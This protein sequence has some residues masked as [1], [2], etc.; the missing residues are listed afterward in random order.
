MK[1][2]IA[3]KQYPYYGGSAT[4]AYKLIKFLRTKH[5]VIGL[6]FNNNS[7]I[8]VD[9]DNLGNIF[10]TSHNSHIKMPTCNSILQEIFNYFNSDPDMILCFNYYV[11]IICKNMFPKSKIVY[12]VVGSPTLTM[13]ENSCVNNNISAVKFLTFKDYNQFIDVKLAELEK[14]S[15]ECS[16]FILV[17]HGELPLRIIKKICNNQLRNKKYCYYDYSGLIL[18]QEINNNNYDKLEKKYD[19]IIIASNWNRIVKNKVFYKKLLLQY[20]NL[21]KIIIGA[22]SN[23]FDKIPNTTLVDLIDYEQVLRY[24]RESKLLLICSY[25]ESGPNIII[26]SI[27]NNCQ[28]LTSK[29]VGKSYFLHDYNLTDDVYDINEWIIKI[30][31]ILANP[32]LKLPNVDYKEDKFFDILSKIM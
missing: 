26:E 16:D 30:N 3:S 27:Y 20:S 4:N 28:V 13:G 15:I 23:Y 9:P 22:N 10:K 18:K 21:N 11:P 12:M 14:K 7:H 25:F 17:D 19:I 29:N 24:L 1:I 31:Y 2:I 32:Q 5:D 8:N 6:Y